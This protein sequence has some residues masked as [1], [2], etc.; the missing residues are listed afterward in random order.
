[1]NGVRA[2]GGRGLVKLG[3]WLSKRHDS[4][5]NLMKRIQQMIATITMAE[6]EERKEKQEVQKAIDGYDPE[7]L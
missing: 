1:M 2:I 7:K 5:S 4:Y 3:A 6:K